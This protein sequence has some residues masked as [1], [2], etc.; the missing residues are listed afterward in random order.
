[1]V[2]VRNKLEAPPAGNFGH[3]P[4]EVLQIELEI[5]ALGVL[6]AKLEVEVVTIP[7]GSPDVERSLPSADTGV[8]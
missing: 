7:N 8:D 2:V 5:R 1:M 4:A 3:A 6:E